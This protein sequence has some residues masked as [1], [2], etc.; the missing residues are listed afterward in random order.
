MCGEV[1][2]NQGLEIL[3]KGQTEE[4][5]SF[6]CLGMQRV[7]QCTAGCWVPANWHAI[8]SGL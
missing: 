4:A 2:E 7:V 8:K 6:K 5:Y 1:L 3:P